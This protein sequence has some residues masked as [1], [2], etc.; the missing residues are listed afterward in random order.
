MGGL[1][2]RDLAL[3]CGQ[4]GM[5]WPQVDG[6]LPHLGSAV[7]AADELIRASAALQVSRR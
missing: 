2:E 5:A 7:T 4:A 6:Q 3:R 1:A